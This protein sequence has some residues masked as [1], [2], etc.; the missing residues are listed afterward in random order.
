MHKFVVKRTLTTDQLHEKRTDFFDFLLRNMIKKIEYDIYKL[1]L[2]CT[3]RFEM[4]C[5]VF[6]ALVNSY[7][8]MDYMC[9]TDSPYGEGAILGIPFEVKTP[10]DMNP[11]EI[12]LYADTPDYYFNGIM[13]RGYHGFEANYCVMD[14][15][16]TNNLYEKFFDN[17]K[18]KGDNMPEIK[19]VI[20]NGPATIVFWK[21]NTK[22]IVKCMPGETF[23]PEKG[24]L[25]ALYKKMSKDKQNY[26]KDIKK[27]ANTYFSTIPVYEEQK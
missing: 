25:V 12:I 4:G 2:D 16:L 21:D 6:N 5:D 8:N 18:R 23:D 15:F 7:F 20:F 19:K 1:G 24:I 26:F 17:V 14:E 9:S 10:M 3:K 27:W 13:P 11:M 22:T